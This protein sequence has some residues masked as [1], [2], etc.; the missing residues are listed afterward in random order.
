MSPALIKPAKTY[1][2]YLE[3]DI[4]SLEHPKKGVAT[5]NEALYQEF[6]M[7]I[8]LARFNVTKSLEDY[9]VTIKERVEITTK[10]TLDRRQGWENKGAAACKMP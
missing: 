7:E 6:V 2:D 8:K 4:C 1:V 10:W 9:R 5:L 3:A